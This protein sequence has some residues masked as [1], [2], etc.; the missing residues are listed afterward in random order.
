ME[1][2]LKE[3]DAADAGYTT[4]W[5]S[6]TFLDSGEDWADRWIQAGQAITGFKGKIQL[7]YLGTRGDGIQG[8][9]AVDDIELKCSAQDTGDCSC[10]DGYRMDLRSNTCVGDIW[11]YLKETGKTDKFVSL[12][13]QA[14]LIDRLSAGGPFTVV[15][16]VD[17]AFS[18]VSIPTEPKAMSSLILG[19]DQL[20]RHHS[21]RG[22]ELAGGLIYRHS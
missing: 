8:D 6:Q 7:R 9:I 16:P 15:V 5:K 17:D 11:S 3:V 18:Q 19:R 12:A 22:E 1:L 4:I 2:Q 14:G 21:H 13:D 20:S 10:D